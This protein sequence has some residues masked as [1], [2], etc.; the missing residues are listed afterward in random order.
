MKEERS[1]EYTGFKALYLAALDSD[2]SLI[3]GVPGY[4]I[5]SLMELFLEKAGE[6]E[7]SEAKTKIFE[8]GNS[9]KVHIPLTVPDGSQTKK[10]PWK[11]LSEHRF[12]AEGPLFL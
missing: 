9:E 12:R 1:R 4:P 5:T 11:P 6:T 2:V 8:A 3:T 7:L 10:L